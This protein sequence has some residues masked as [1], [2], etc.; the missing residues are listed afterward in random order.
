MSNI[1]IK[2]V[3]TKKEIKAF[4]DFPIKLFKDVQNFVPYMYSDELK[5][6]NHKTTYEK[7]ATSIF[8]LA[9]KDNKVV[10]RIS[11][12]IQHTYNS[13]MNISQARFTRFDCI[14]D[15]E[16]ATALFNQVKA[17]AK[18]QK[19]TS[20][21]GPLDYSD[22]E[23]EGLLIEG[24]DEVMTFEEQF[25]P[26]DYKDLI[27]ANGF[28]K[29]IDWFEFQLTYDKESDEKIAKL[30]KGVR[31]LAKV[32]VADMNI[33][34]AKYI[35]KYKKPVFDLID[36]C[37]GK[38]YGT[39]PLNE[40]TRDGIISQFGPLLQP[41]YLPVV[42]NDKGE[43]IAFGLCFPAIGDALRKSGG[44]LTLPAL[45]KMLKLINKPKALELC[46]VAVHPDYQNTGIN[47]LFLE[48]IYKTFKEKNVQYCETNLNLETNTAV[49]SQW[50]HFNARQHKR[51]RC[52]K[53]SLQD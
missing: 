14:N 35:S 9:Y 50:K 7:E 20:L 48:D 49:I 32:K 12:I 43:V 30:A 51:R 1:L 41:E 34:R 10:G 27:S 8:Y 22:L 2:E 11:G 33:P 39:M 23:R 16:V 36:I 46:L 21:V 26:P 4:I 25:H 5:V 44:K 45:I 19:M 17:W 15:L 52:Y 3:K 37:Y 13:K 24:F 53:I 31:R 29:E 28:E 38:L 42:E 40:E 47:A 18:A 6:L